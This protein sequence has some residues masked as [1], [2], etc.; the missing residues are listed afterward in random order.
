MTHPRTRRITAATP[1][2]A[3]TIAIVLSAATGA[4]TAS[5]F[6]YNSTGSM[7]QQP[8]PTS[9]AL[10]HHARTRQWPPTAPAIGTAIPQPL[11]PPILPRIKPRN[12]PGPNRPN[13]KL[14]RTRH[15]TDAR[16]A[17]RR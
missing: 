1:A 11:R 12:S 13:G 14:L 5:T 15:R 16:T 4:A 6:N 10:S 3:L 8:S 17:L 9:V 2:L 7:V